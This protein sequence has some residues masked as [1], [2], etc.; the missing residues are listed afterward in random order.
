M[1]LENEW[2]LA[3][4]VVFVTFDNNLLDMLTA[5]ING[6]HCPSSVGG[7]PGKK[8]Q[9]HSNVAYSCLSWE[10]Y[11]FWPIFVVLE[12]WN[13]MGLGVGAVT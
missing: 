13:M 8:Q 1:G 7:G 9:Q 4:V 5:S 10:T 11:N 3:C 2:P 12:V 6:K